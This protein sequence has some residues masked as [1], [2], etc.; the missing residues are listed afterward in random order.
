MEM[1]L[2]AS[3]SVVLYKYFKYLGFAMITLSLFT[4]ASLS[5]NLVMLFVMGMLKMM[6]EMSLKASCSVVL[7]KYVKYL[8]FAIIKLSLF[9]YASLSH[10]LVML[11]V[12]GML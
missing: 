6:V 9:T 8:G 4:Y 5:H 3:C 10:N 7:Y 1:S 11:F 12:M 2:K